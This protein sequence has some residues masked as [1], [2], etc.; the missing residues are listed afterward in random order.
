M[1][2][3]TGFAPT[4]AWSSLPT[5]KSGSASMETAGAAPGRH[6]AWCGR[7]R[8]RRSHARRRSKIYFCDVPGNL[9]R[10]LFWLSVES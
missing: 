10:P 5:E 9:R 4:A 3:T 7:I 6:R 1:V 2:A 8:G